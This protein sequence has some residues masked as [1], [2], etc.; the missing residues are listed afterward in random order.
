MRARITGW[1]PALARQAEAERERR[2]KDHP[3]RG[4]V[5]GCGET[6]HGCRTIQTTRR[7]STPRSASGTTL[8]SWLRTRSRS[9]LTTYRQSLR[10]ASAP[11]CLRIPRTFAPIAAFDVSARPDLIADPFRAG[12]VMNN[13]NAGCHA[14]IAQGGLAA[15]QVRTPGNW[16]NPCAFAAPVAGLWQCRPEHFDWSGVRGHSVG[17]CLWQ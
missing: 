15:D 16:F 5:L 11:A 7:S 8:A 17:E 1:W 12:P 6:L 9:R 4:R 3:C 2:A 13:P 14:T 10:A